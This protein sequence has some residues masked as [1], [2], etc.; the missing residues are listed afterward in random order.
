MG[1]LNGKQGLAAR[2][3]GVRVGA[4]ELVSELSV[5]FSPGEV[6]A[7]LGRNGSGKTLT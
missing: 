4:R 6:V 1:A 5:E 2:Q 7:I 3:V